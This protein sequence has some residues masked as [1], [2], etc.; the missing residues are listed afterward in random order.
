MHALLT[1][2][3]FALLTPAPAVDGLDPAALA[4]WNTERIELTR[5]GM[6]V[7][8]G[9]GA[10]SVAAGAIGYAIADD[11]RWR[12]FHLMT[13]GWGLVDLGLAGLSLYNNDPAAAAT[14]GPA[15]SLAAQLGIERILLFN[16][17]LDVG[18][19]TLGAW[20]WERGLRKS[21][22]R[23]EGFGQA[24]LI[25][26]AFLLAFDLGLYGLEAQHGETLRLMLTPGGAG[27]AGVF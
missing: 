23:L 8:G 18:Y 9:W 21:D 2:A 20:L 5:D 4:A 16:A 10:A 13:A 17:G 27:V 15:E 6:Y 7:L 3:L 11:A 12:G 26:G 25:Q 19:L 14:L 1:L 22:P 24:I